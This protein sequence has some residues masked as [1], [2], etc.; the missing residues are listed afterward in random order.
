MGRS[1]WHERRDERRV[2]CPNTVWHHDRIRFLASRPNPPHHPL[3]YPT[4]SS[5]HQFSPPPM[6]D[7]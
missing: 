1:P 2:F 7:R 5:S 4:P 3:T 6:I